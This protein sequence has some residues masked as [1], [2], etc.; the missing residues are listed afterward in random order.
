M[1]QFTV[2]TFNNIIVEFDLSMSSVERAFGIHFQIGFMQKPIIEVCLVIPIK[3]KSKSLFYFRGIMLNSTIDCRVLNI[4]VSFG[5]DFLKFTIAIPHLQ[6]SRTV[7]RMIM[8]V[9]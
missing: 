5:Q 6:Y 9:T 2:I 1:L 4:H 8:S 3:T 7:Y